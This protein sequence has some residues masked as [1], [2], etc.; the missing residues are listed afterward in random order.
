M[1]NF[2]IN[3]SLLNDKNLNLPYCKLALYQSFFLMLTC[4]LHYLDAAVCAHCGICAVC[5]QCTK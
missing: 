4:Q 3:V 2:G 5:A 1:D